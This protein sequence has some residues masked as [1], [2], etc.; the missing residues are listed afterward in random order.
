VSVGALFGVFCTTGSSA[1]PL[2]QEWASYS[3]DSVRLPCNCCIQFS[4]LTWVLMPVSSVLQAV[5]RPCA[6]SQGAY[7]QL[8][9]HQQVRRHHHVPAGRKQPLQQPPPQPGEELCAER[10]VNS[11]GSSSRPAAVQ[12]Q[13]RST[14][15]RPHGGAHACACTASS[16]AQQLSQALSLLPNTCN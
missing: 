4:Q 8:A 11:S 5:P 14:C 15:H 12:Q 2:H 3:G 6:Q 7:R 9:P 1:R 13:P 10:Q 16:A